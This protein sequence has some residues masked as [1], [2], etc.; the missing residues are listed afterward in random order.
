M[1]ERRSSS[2]AY[3]RLLTHPI[4]S[5][6][7]KGRGRNIICKPLQAAQEFHQ[8]RVVPPAACG[9]V[10]GGERSTGG[11]HP[12][13]LPRSQTLEE[14]EEP[15]RGAIPSGTGVE[16]SGPRQRLLLQSHVGFQVDLCRLGRLVAEPECNDG[17]IHAA[18]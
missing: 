6:T 13:L 7:R 8:G 18:L 4:P 17:T 15:I 12:G 11:K 10:A 3:L 9:S 1:S 2:D 16:G 5:G 14:F